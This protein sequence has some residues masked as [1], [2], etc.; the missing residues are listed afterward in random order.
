MDPQRIYTYATPGTRIFGPGSLNRL[1]K[2]LAGQT[3]PMV[4]TDQ[5]LVKAG[6]VDKVVAVLDG[7]GLKSAVYD[8]VPPDPP[9]ESID[10]AAEL[11]AAEGCDCILALGG[12]SPMDAAKG[13]AV[14]VSHGDDLRDYCKSKSISQ[15]L[16]PLVAIPT[17]AGTGSEV[18]FVAVISDTQDKVKR[19]L[20][21]VQLVPQTSILDPLLLAGLPP[22][23]AAET[24][25]DALSHALEGLATRFAQPLSEA[26]GLQAVR[27]IS[28]HLRALVADPSN[29][30]AAGNMLLASTLASMCW[31]GVGLGLV[32][33]LAHPLGAHHHVSH[34]KACALYLPHVMDFNLIACPRQYALAAQAMGQDIAGLSP[35]EAARMAPGA[36]EELLDDIGVA[37]TYG[38]L[39]V[40]FRLKEEMVKEV[41]EGPNRQTNPRV[42]DQGQIEA[43]FNAPG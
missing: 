1:P 4:V 7:A 38:E 37:A 13:L 8:Q 2:V 16:P 35:L 14:K 36:V 19:M 12:G 11:Y 30:E 33:A 21:G 28:E 25:A 10:Q 6:I 5:G 39:G 23:I 22:A 31:A 34:G 27:L 18:T 26:Q 20:R 42:S 24:G 43:L 17:T 32:H 3:K 15:K 29:V 9:F 40:D 41:M